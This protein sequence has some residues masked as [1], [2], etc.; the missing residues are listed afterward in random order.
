MD[1]TDVT[2]G[3]PARIQLAALHVGTG[4]RALIS[5][6]IEHADIRVEGASLTLPL[7]SLGATGPPAPTAGESK[8]PVEIVSI[9]EIVLRDVE[10][11]SGGRTVARRHRAGAARR[12]RRD[13]PDGPG[14]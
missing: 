3:K 2:I 12:R 10:V 1:L 11:V 14:R 4:V 6:R 9:D 5:R 13:P 7:P 8:P